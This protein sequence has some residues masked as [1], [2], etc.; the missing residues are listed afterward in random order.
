MEP[1][2]TPTKRIQRTKRTLREYGKES[3]LRGSFSIDFFVWR[4]YNVKKDE[5][6]VGRIQ[7]EE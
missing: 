2:K 1:R 7:N 5:S 3:R 6:K 4:D